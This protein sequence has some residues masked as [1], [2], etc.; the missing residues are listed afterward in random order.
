MLSKPLLMA[1][2]RDC[3]SRRCLV[4]KTMLDKVQTFVDPRAHLVGGELRYSIKIERTWT[5]RVL[6]NTEM[7]R[8]FG[9]L[10]HE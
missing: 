2:L 10:N 6:D 7:Y 3:R 9:E 4:Q 8:I 1:M 5:R